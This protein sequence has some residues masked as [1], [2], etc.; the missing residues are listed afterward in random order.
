MS[1]RG[2]NSG[3]CLT[4]GFIH[5]SNANNPQFVETF[6]DLCVL[7]FYQ[8]NCQLIMITVSEP[9]TRAVR[10]AGTGESQRAAGKA[11]SNKS[12]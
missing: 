2:P 6:A 9:Q 11:L 1:Q 5:I 7:P 3:E 10:D 8:R 12:E 4:E